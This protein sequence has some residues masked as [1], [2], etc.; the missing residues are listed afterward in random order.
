VEEH[1]LEDTFMESFGKEEGW[2]NRSSTATCEGRQRELQS[3]W[4]KNKMKKK[5]KGTGRPN[6]YS[7]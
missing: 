4:G 7:K 1:T 6:R 5:K 3:G 2:R